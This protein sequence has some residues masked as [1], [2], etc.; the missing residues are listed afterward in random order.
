[1]NPAPMP[2]ILCG[3]GGPPDRTGEA[4]GSTAITRQRWLRDFSTSPAPVIVPP[5]PTPATNA[6]TRPSSA[7]QISGPVVRRW[8]SGLAGLENWSGRNTPPSVGQ[9]AGRVDRLV[10]PP[11]R[12]GDLDPGAVQ[13]QQALAFAAHALRHGQHQLIALGRAHERQ[14]DP[15]VAAGRL[16]D[17]RPARLDD[18]VALGRLDHRHADAVL[19]AP[20]G[21]ERLQLREQPRL[22]VGEHPW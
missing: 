9:R 15:G 8:I 18:A 5:V 3:P 19:D 1:M 11:Q 10:H 17:R 22:P 6:S 7:S 13:S 12:L 14:R 20:A 16:D 4:L 2:W 21:V